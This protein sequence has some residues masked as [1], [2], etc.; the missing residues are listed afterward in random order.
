MALPLLAMI[1]VTAA[2]GSGAPPARVPPVVLVAGDSLVVAATADLEGFTPPGVH[3][4]VLA[5]VGASP[6]DLWAGYRA[7]KGFGGRYL[8]FTAALRSNRPKAVV[9]AFTGNP[10]TSANA[11]IRHPST[12]YRLSTIVSRYRS[13]LLAMGDL[14][15]RAGARIYLSATPARNPSV[16]EGREDGV[17]NGYNGD[18]AFNAMMSQLAAAERWSYD[19]D[20]AAAISGAGLG[21][22]LT[23]PCQTAAGVPCTGGRQQ[24][25]YGGPDAIHC[26]APGTNGPEAPSDGSLR[27]AHG[28]LVAPL[29]G[30]GRR[31]LDEVH[32]EPNPSTT[33]TCAP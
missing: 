26:D 24:V 31:P 2:C 17:E 16:P 4:A 19:S 23:L 25:R 30:L 28:L 12:A 6:C 14:A 8:S 33:T 3:T 7:P 18:P 32:V 27:F 11:C 21:W 9:L 13:A 5:G 20:A 22:T 10:G 15:A 1:C 29:A